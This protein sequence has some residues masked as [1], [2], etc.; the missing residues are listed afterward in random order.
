[1]IKIKLDPKLT[2]Q[3]NAGYYFTKAGNERKAYEK[4]KELFKDVSGNYSR[5][6][7]LKS[8]FE[9]S[10]NIEELDKFMKELHIKQNVKVNN[11]DDIVSRFKHY[12]IEN[13]YDL[14]VGKDSSN[15]DLLTMKFAKQNDYWFHARSVPGSHVVLRVI[16]TKEPVPKNILKSAASIAAF[17]SKAKTSGIAPVSYTFKKYVTKKKGMEPGKVV[18]LKEEVLLVR[19]EIPSNCEYVSGE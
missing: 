19:P 12:I 14:Y 7:Q 9:Q 10:E 17:H 18:L 3:K 6:L 4:S 1:M 11:A 5:L 16:N 2:P 15:N 13:K 8:R